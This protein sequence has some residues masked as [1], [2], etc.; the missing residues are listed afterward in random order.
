M[1]C[2]VGEFCCKRHV[3]LNTCYLNCRISACMCQL[4]VALKVD[5]FLSFS[6]SLHVESDAFTC[7]SVMQRKNDKSTVYNIAI[8]LQYEVKD[9]NYRVLRSFV[10]SSTNF[11][12]QIFQS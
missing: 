4:K 10:G 5:R 12:R 9:G 7:F 3:R 11:N 6:L 1:C 8:F 2:Q